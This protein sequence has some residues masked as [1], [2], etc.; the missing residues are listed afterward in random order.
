M[1]GR[2]A[3]PRDFP[4]DT[5]VPRTITISPGIG[6]VGKID[7]LRA[8]VQPGRSTRNANEYNDVHRD[9][10]ALHA[11]RL[12][13]ALRRGGRSASSARAT[14]AST[15]SGQGRRRPAGAPARPLLHPRR[16]RP[17]SR[18]ARASASTREL[19]RFSPRD[20]GEPLDGVGQYLYPVASD[21][22]QDRRYRGDH[23]L[24][25]PKLPTPPLPKQAQPRPKRPGKT[26]G[27]QDA[28]SKHAE[29]GGDRKRSTGSTSARRCRASGAG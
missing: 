1:A 2:S 28:R 15:T 27:P 26:D 20:P 19:R 9:L 7:R 10:D 4:H 11:P 6:E 5:Y 13:G 14:A 25:M 22:P 8:Q 24:E 29:D 3:R 23:G 16:R 18:S 17:A 21:D 12:P